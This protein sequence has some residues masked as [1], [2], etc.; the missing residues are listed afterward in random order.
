MTPD[1]LISKA[2][3]D[4]DPDPQ[5]ATTDEIAEALANSPRF[6]R[7]MTSF[8][9]ADCRILED[10]MHSWKTC[11]KGLRA[12]NERANRRNDSLRAALFVSLLSTVALILWRL[13]E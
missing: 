3:R 9:C 6:W 13:S 7:D 4:L 1:E 8:D 5:L 11:A 10:A 2:I 12:A